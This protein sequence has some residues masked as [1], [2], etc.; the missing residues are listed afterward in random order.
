YGKKPLSYHFD[1]KR[2]LFASEAKAILTY[3]G[4]VRE[5]DPAA[6]DDYIALGY[7]PGPRSAFKGMSK[8]PAAHYLLLTDGNIEIR[9]YWHLAFRPK[10]ELSEEEAGA[11]ILARLTKA[12]RLRMIGDVPI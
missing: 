8:L 7:V 12:V 2:M 5:P 11:E 4:F 9:R 1:G 3:P 6:I 10:L